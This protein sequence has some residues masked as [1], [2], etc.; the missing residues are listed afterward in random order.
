MQLRVHVLEALLS[1]AFGAA[2]ADARAPPAGVRTARAPAWA[3]PSAA[4][5]ALG[6]WDADDGAPPRFAISAGPAGGGALDAPRA[7][8]AVSSGAASAAA[9]VACIR[10]DPRSPLARAACAPLGPAVPPSS[11]PAQPGGERPRGPS[12][13][14]SAEV[15]QWAQPPLSQPAAQLAMPQHP[16]QHRHYTQPLPLPP[17]AP[18]GLAAPAA[19]SP[20]ALLARPST[21]DSA[22]DAS[23]MLRLREIVTK[24]QAQL[25]RSDRLLAARRLLELTA[26][27]DDRALG[28]ALHTD[29]KRAGV[30]TEWLLRERGRIVDRSAPSSSRDI[31]F[32]QSELASYALG[33]LRPITQLIAQSEQDMMDF[34]NYVNKWPKLAALKGGN[35]AAKKKRKGKDPTRDKAGEHEVEDDDGAFVLNPPAH[36]KPGAKSQKRLPGVHEHGRK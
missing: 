28:A 31:T 17:P 7:A 29:A 27:S 1:T 19:P 18:P 26:R 15:A 23:R 25:A 4:G 34:L 35:V 2:V 36:I 33:Q 9:R 6:P 12:H 5:D 11:A 16:P 10:A 22:S 3:E 21:A 30:F 13:S 24:Q 20:P 32:T 8:P 14:P